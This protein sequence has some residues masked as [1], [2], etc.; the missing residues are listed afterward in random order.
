MIQAA[1]FTT[2]TISIASASSQLVI[3]YYRAFSFF[4]GISL[5]LIMGACTPSQEKP[6]TQESTHSN[7]QLQL[8]DPQATTETK[9]LY[10]NLATISKQGFLFGHEDSQAYG[11]GW[12]ADENQSDV[13]K[14]TGTFP[15]VNGWD[16]GKILQDRNLDSIRF[17]LMIDRIKAT[18]QRGGVTTISW[19][20][21][22]PLSGGSSWD[23]TPAV[24]ACLPDGE[25]HKAFLEKLEAAAAFLKKCQA[26]DGTPIPI[27]FRPFHEHNGNW[28]W[29][30]KGHCSEEDYI[31]LWRF[32]VDYFRKEKNLHN[33]IIAFSPDRSRLGDDRI[34][35]DY[36][37]GY[38]GDQYVD[39]IGLD[40]YW[41]V[42]H[43]SNSKSEEVRISH[44][45]ESLATITQIAKEK[46]KIAALTETGMD[47]TAFAF[48]SR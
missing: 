10:T 33:L 41:D 12:W 39:I 1:H 35:E 29:W 40:N 15:A 36:F 11:V 5:I 43:K 8:T 27:I 9:A 26:E 13:K 46:G 2:G 32:T 42:G 22:N 16:L 37:Y 4:I 6:L 21:L 28:F 34:H 44:F 25:A 20:M 45:R 7:K 24:K 17:D 19:H 48:K 47:G 38:P 3:P 23:K 31:A 18:Y 14:L 30:G